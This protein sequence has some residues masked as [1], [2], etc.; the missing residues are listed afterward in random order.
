MQVELLTNGG[1]K[2]LDPCIGKQFDVLNPSGNSNG[3]V[4][5]DVVQLRQAG[6]VD[7]GS[8]MNSLYFFGWEVRVID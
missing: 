7:D 2:G 8:N 1:Y 4:R 3:S 6:Y 5:L